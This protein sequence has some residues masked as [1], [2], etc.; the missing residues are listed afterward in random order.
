MNRRSFLKW[1]T[2]FIALAVGAGTGTAISAWRRS[3]GVPEVVEPAVAKAESPSSSED[4]KALASFA[5]LSDMHVTPDDTLTIQH[6]K[7]ALT[8]VTTFGHPVDAIFFTGDVTDYG[9]DRDYKELRKLM[10]GYKLPP[11]HA[12]M[13]NHEYYDLWLDAEGSFNREGMPNGKT[14][15]MARSRFMKFFG[16]KQPYNRMDIGGATVLLLSQ[17]GY[18]Q[19][20]P[21]A[22]EGAWYTDAQMEWLK[23]QLAG[24]EKTAPIFI[25]IH[26]PL[27]MKGRT[28]GNHQI[29]RGEEIREMVKPYKNLFVFCGHRHQDF[30]NGAAHYLQEP[31]HYFHNSSVGRTLNKSI[32]Q[33]NKI[34]TQGLYVQVFAGKV[35]VRGRDYGTKQ[36]LAEADWTIPLD[37]GK[38]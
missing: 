38:V 31:F 11:V 30:Q 1:M 7:S 18:M 33:V 15:S 23:T 19:E 5:I 20:K 22:G 28:G 12:N 36:W 27:P 32:P 17:E 16:Y 13:G 2:A 14:D 35:V 24:L 34:K 3:S 4:G 29:V 6:A 8:D 21:E 37:T 9:R 10:Q 26:Q 25:M